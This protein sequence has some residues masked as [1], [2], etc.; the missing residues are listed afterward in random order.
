MVCVCVRDE[1]LVGCCSSL[2]M[3]LLQGGE[4]EVGFDSGIDLFSEVVVVLLNITDAAGGS[5]VGNVSKGFAMV[6][7]D[8]ESCAGS[9]GVVLIST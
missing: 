3:V 7:G 6:A 9:S 4:V 5:V 2:R 1:R 8:S